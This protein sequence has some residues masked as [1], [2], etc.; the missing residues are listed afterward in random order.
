MY[1]AFLSQVNAQSFYFGPK[2]GPTIGLQ[3]WNSFD[4]DPLLAQHFAFM[5]ETP[6]PENK[7]ALYAQLGYHLRG[8]SIFSNNLSTFNLQRDP[9]KFRNVSLQ[10][11]AKKKLSQTGKSS[12]YYLFGARLEYTLSDNLDIYEERNLN[13]PIFPF[14]AFVRRFNYG[15]TVGGGWEWKAN[16]FYIPFIEINISPDFSLQYQQPEIGN[17]SDPIFGG[18]RIIREREIRNITFEVSFGIKFFREVI[19]ID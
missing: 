16:E 13:F 4:R 10:V 17:I 7:G 18:T 14:E 2:L 1:S 9:I 6:D 8:S 12:P 11:G 3:S 5:I 15:V 19:Y